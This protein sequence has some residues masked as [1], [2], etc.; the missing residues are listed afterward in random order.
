MRSPGAWPER[1]PLPCLSARWQ[2]LRNGLPP[3]P[4]PILVECRL[5]GFR[6]SPEDLATLLRSL[7]PTIATCHHPAGGKD[8]AT[9]LQWALE[10]GAGAVDLD[11]QAPDETVRKVLPLA[12]AIGARVIRS[13][14]RSEDTPPIEVLRRLVQACFDAGAE[15]AKVVTMAQGPEDG[16]RI[17]DLYQDAPRPLV[18]FCMGEAG[19]ES[20]FGSVRRGA[21]WLY[22]TLRP[23]APTAPGQPTLEEAARALGM[24]D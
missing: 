1:F 12:R 19:R 14:H 9:L 3:V 22:C 5:E 6:G 8:P 4:F 2:D 21:P 18:A 13:V 24:G 7:P 16:L 23:D 10:A 20:R 15:I 17:L 11:L